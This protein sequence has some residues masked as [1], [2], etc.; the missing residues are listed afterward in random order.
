MGPGV[1]GLL[2]A[3][4]GNAT[5]LIISLFA[6]RAGLYEV[7]KASISGSI[8]GNILLVLGLSMFVG[9]LGRDKQTFSRTRAGASAAMLFLAV[10][11]LVM[12]AVFEL[13]IFGTLGY[14]TPR[15][16]QLSLL[17]AIVLIFTYF[18]SLVFSL[19]T[20]REPIT[21]MPRGEQEPRLSLGNSIILL[22]L[23]TARRRGRVRT[24]GG[25]NLRG[26]QSH[27]G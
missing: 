25:R 6:L 8:I 1:G 12:P 13:A 15:V 11:A 27:W 16:E 26:Y 5:E 21:N 10:V 2:N 22:F 23:A 3:T 24:T 17:V 18:A 20:H 19:K 7:V 14:R 9:G 4:F